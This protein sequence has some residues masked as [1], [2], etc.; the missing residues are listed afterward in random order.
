MLT[1]DD[2]WFSEWR[3]REQSR[4][5][6]AGITYLD[7]TGAALHP[8]SLVRDELARLNTSV[9]GNPHSESVP[10]RASTDD[11]T[12]AR[13]AI[14]DFLKASPDEYTVILTPNASAACRLVGESFPFANGSRL[15]LAADNHNSVNGIR[16]Y[17]RRAGSSVVV[18]PLDGELRLRDPS[19]IFGKRRRARSLFAFPAQSNFSGVRHPLDLVSAAH[20]WGWRILLDA[21]SFLPSA[22]LRLDRIYPDFVVLSVYKI[23]GYPTGIGA[24]VARRDALAELRRPWFAGGTVQWVSVSEGRHRLLT[25]PEAFEDGTPPFHAAGA[26]PRALAAV[27][28]VSRERLARHL[29]CLTSVA[30]EQLQANPLVTVHGPLTTVDRGA[31][32]ALTLRDDTGRVVPYWVVEEAARAEGIAVRGGC[33]CNPGCAEAAFGFPAGYVSRCLEPLG[34]DFTIPRFAACLAGGPVGAIRISLG[35]GSV[36]RDVERVADFLH[37]PLEMPVA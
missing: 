36:R 33:F 37:Q 32:I 16:E 6:R 15:A 34:D 30:L 9:L 35:L 21:A 2:A 17:A 5:D 25:G 10:S 22:D 26:V 31:T 23:T 11:L 12:K 3:G 7:Y 24:L 4:V 14:L 19:V 1:S 8:E 27:A 18:L 28:E 29:R 13:A 20:R